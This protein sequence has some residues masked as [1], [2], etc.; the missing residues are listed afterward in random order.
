MLNAADS[1]CFNDEF[2][3]KIRNRS[4]VA[5][6]GNKKR[7]YSWAIPLKDAM[8]LLK[9]TDKWFYEGLMYKEKEQSN[10]SKDKFNNIY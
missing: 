1:G 4:T 5:L 2:T 10:L 8:Y 7:L 6:P 9:R 3:E